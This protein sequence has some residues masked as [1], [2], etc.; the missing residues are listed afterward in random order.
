MKIERVYEILVAS[1]ILNFCLFV[2]QAT[3][4]WGYWE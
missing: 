1:V 2:I 4:L 3:L